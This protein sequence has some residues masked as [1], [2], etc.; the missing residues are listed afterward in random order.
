MVTRRNILSRIQ[1]AE[2]EENHNRIL[3]DIRECTSIIRKHEPDFEPFQT[4]TSRMLQ[5]VAIERRKIPEI[6]FEPS[7]IN[8]NGIGLSEIWKIKGQ[9]TYL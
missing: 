7:I 1:W 6:L 3:Q 8:L 4:P 5:G 9:G 2:D